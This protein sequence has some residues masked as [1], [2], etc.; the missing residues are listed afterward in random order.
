M[1]DQGLFSPIFF[2][3]W[4]FPKSTFA[5]R[6]LTFLRFLEG[7]APVDTLLGESWDLEIRIGW[8]TVFEGACHGYESAR[9]SRRSES[10][11]PIS[12]SGLV[13][14]DSQQGPIEDDG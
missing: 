5:S 1:A 12:A 11:A 6:V 4:C 3:T 10:L 9:R 2:F 13:L 7:V 14:N 8:S